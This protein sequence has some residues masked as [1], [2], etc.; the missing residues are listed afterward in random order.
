MLL[1]DASAARM[2]GLPAVAVTASVAGT[3]KPATFW[4]LELELAAEEV[5]W[6][7]LTRCRGRGEGEGARLSSMAD[8]RLLRGDEGALGLSD[9]LSLA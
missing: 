1:V 8:Q 7:E 2:E 3:C 4:T 5:E 6:F 9:I